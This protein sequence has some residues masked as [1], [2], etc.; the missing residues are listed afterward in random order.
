MVTL[1]R[2]W[3]MWLGERLLAAGQMTPPYTQ[4]EGYLRL[5]VTDA[6]VG[7]LSC[8]ENSIAHPEEPPAWERAELLYEEPFGAES[9]SQNWV[10]VGEPP[11]AHDGAFRF[12]P[13][14]NHVLRRRFSGPLAVDC[15][16]TPLPTEEYSAGVTDAI[17]IW[18]LDEPG[19]D[20]PETLAGLPDPSLARLMP[21]P[22]YWVDMGGT[23]NQ[24]TRLR[25]NPDRH[26]RRQFTDRARLLDR[27]RTYRVTLVQ[28][29]H[30]AEY[31]VDGE[32]WI[33][34]RDSEPLAEGHVGFRAFIGGLEISELRV[35]RIR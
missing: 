28:N 20:L 17:F 9:L 24:T 10:S 19:G 16:A 18:M 13:M 8:E 2:D 27:D 14:S 25:R 32:P 6:D 7:I 3:A 26:L 1:D 15:V 29:G 12:T 23:N 21:L 33:R 35:W 34:L 11:Q 31:W 22:F 5:Q 30:F 4:N